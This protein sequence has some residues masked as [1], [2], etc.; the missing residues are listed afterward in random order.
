MRAPAIE[1]GEIVA[2]GDLRG[3]APEELA[4]AQAPA[5]RT[6]ETCLLRGSGQEGLL[7]DEVA[8]RDCAAIEDSSEEGSACGDAVR[9]ESVGVEDA[10]GE[11]LC[12]PTLRGEQPPAQRSWA[13]V[14]RVAVV[15]AAALVQPATAGR[16]PV[17]TQLSMGSADP[18]GLGFEE[19]P[20]PV[21]RKAAFS[22]LA[23]ARAD[24][25]ELMQRPFAQLNVA[26]VTE[27][28]AEPQAVQ[29]GAPT[30]TRLD[31]IV[32][33]ETL[34]AI[35]AWRRRLRRCMRFAALGDLVKARAL[36]PPDLWLPAC[37]NMT[38]AA[39][40]WD[41][42]LRPLAWGGSPVPWPPSG[43]DGVA[44]S[45]ALDLAAVA[46]GAGAVY[47]AAQ[48]CVRW[49]DEA[50]RVGGFDDR[51]IIDEMVRGVSDDAACV[52]GSLLCAPH[53]SALQHLAT[54]NAKLDAV[55][56]NGWGFASELPAW[57]V[58]ACP[59]GVVDESERAGK[60]KWRLTN[61]LSWPPPFVMRDGDGYVTSLNA[62]MQRGAW[63]KGSL[64]R[65]AE[66]A[67]AAAV[68]RVAQAPVK[69]WTFDCEAFYKAM[70]RQNA[71]LWKVAMMR[72]D[73]CQ[74]D[75]RC[76]FGS[77]ADAAKCARVSNFIAHH[78]RVA[79]EG[80]DAQ[81]PPRDSR[82]L[83]WIDA[84]RRAALAAGAEAASYC[85]LGVSGVYV[86]DALGVS[87]DD[88][89]LG[90]DGQPVMRGGVQLTRAPA[91]FE[92]AL[93]A[94]QRFGF[95]SAPSKEHPPALRAV[96]LGVELDVSEGW[97]R[98]EPR[99]R[100]LY[101]RRVREALGQR[102]VKRKLF[103][104]LLGR[105]QFAAVCYPRGRQWMNAAWRAARARY[106]LD[107]DKVAMTKSVVRDLRRWEVALED[108]APP[109]VPLAAV[110]KARPMGEDGVGAMYADAS[111]QQGWAAWTC[112]GTEVVLVEGEWTDAE[113]VGLDI[114]VKELHASTAG[115]VTLVPEM[116]ASDVHNYTDSMV[117]LGV[118]RSAVSTAPRL[119]ALTAARIDWMLQAGVVEAAERIGSKS[120]LWADLASR[121]ASAEVERQA[122]LL[123]LSFRRV[124][125][126]AGWGSA[127]WLLDVPVE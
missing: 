56:E 42:D 24:A 112:V 101:L 102:T 9:G 54:A 37:S 55:V 75:S 119:Q 110:A 122:A 92:A 91:H 1:R 97:M 116:R 104:K 76:C 57:P 62:S 63:P 61:D 21:R 68:M 4:C 29:P 100:S 47:D 78:I 48:A 111:G 64:V 13:S 72:E 113:R 14:A 117:A 53:F 81:F 25:E 107:G 2:A 66:V 58:R 52:R 35:N 7:R 83:E 74:V 126:A 50:E 88:A 16:A 41:W 82:V 19:R 12:E 39:R 49:P 95:K 59:Y 38:E 106:R 125:A 84:R 89:L 71:Q 121:D 3:R 108:T 60:P 15:A 77:A 26:P 96:M 28:M 67:E 5:S 80:V 85:A 86:D 115:L 17:A 94:V 8:R 46:E 10:R 51:A 98:L 79:I 123:G 34:A 90:A 43:R 120:N 6:P 27:P 124:Q 109:T 70:G 127:A 23:H 65:V 105:L 118:M 18:H 20:A 30:F 93:R 11:A 73:A 31:Q 114:S 45:T 99:K 33:K 69:L 87:F 36:R 32:P 40:P 103:L 22:A 44:P